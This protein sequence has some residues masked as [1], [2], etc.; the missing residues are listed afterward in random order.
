L[1]T[2]LRSLATL[3]GELEDREAKIRRLVDA[4][5]IGVLISDLEGQIIEANDAFLDMAGYTRDDVA[6]GQLRW[7]DMTPAE[8]QGASERAVAPGKSDRGL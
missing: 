8:W 7:T 4:N 5:I 3:H 1:Q 6:S 2:D